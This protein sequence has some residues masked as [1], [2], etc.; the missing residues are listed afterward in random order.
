MPATPNASSPGPDLESLKWNV[1]PPTTAAKSIVDNMLRDDNFPGYWDHSS[2]NIKTDDLEALYPP[3]TDR[4]QPQ[5]LSSSPPRQRVS[6]LKLEEPLSPWTHPASLPSEDILTNSLPFFQIPASTLSDDDLRRTF[7]E[8]IE[9]GALRVQSTLR[10]EKLKEADYTARVKVPDLDIQQP[11]AP[12]QKQYSRDEELEEL[13][14]LMLPIAQSKLHHWSATKLE[15]DLVWTPFPLI[16][17]VEEELKDVGGFVEHFTRL[18]VDNC[19]KT[20]SLTWKPEGLRLL[21]HNDSDDDE[22]SEIEEI[23]EQTRPGS[24]HIEA[25]PMTMSRITVAPSIAAPVTKA[26]TLV[27]RRQHPPAEGNPL[28]FSSLL[29]DKVVSKPRQTSIPIATNADPR[30]C[31]LYTSPSPRD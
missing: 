10:N 12:W 21:N 2:D 30:S 11:L 31:L 24:S 25:A 9:P 14:Q 26:V 3:L 27:Q 29:N 19:V 6:R 22:L 4:H 20:E 23:E 15:R 7:E 1:T 13:R 17:N 28:N 5:A 18:E 8:I 16:V